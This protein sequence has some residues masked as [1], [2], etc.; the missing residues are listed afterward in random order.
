LAFQ[1]YF[2]VPKAWKTRKIDSSN[3]NSY[4]NSK[5]SAPL[6]SPLSC[7]KGFMGGGRLAKKV[8]QM[9]LMIIRKA[10]SDRRAIGAAFAALMVFSGCAGEYNSVKSS[11]Q[12]PQS[13]ASQQQSIPVLE[14]SV[15]AN[16]CGRAAWEEG[17]Q[18]TPVVAFRVLSPDEAKSKMKDSQVIILDVRTPQEFDEGH[19]DGAMPLPLDDLEKDAATLLPD[20]TTEILVVCR[21][22]VRSRIAAGM[23]AEMGYVNV[24]DA[25]G[26]EQ[27]S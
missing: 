12:S 18:Q 20:K 14:E 24:F 1:E 22:G 3:C 13:P 26:I 2:C 15:N 19:L 25:G 8:N 9:N 10:L 6:P 16:P 7:G 5:Y 21:S 27:L 23:L 11:E 17:Q 4:N